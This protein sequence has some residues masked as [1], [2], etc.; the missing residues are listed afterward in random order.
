MAYKYYLAAKFSRLKEM[1]KISKLIDKKL[2]W[3]CTATWTQNSEEGKSRRQIATMD[4]ADVGR[5]DVLFIFTHPRGEPQPGGGRFVEMGYALGKGIPVIVI[6]DYENVFTHSTQVS[7]YP[8]LEDF[9]M[10]RAPV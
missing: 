9:F 2:G 6:G 1:A 8:T 10:D 7:R 5:A 3:E 4:L